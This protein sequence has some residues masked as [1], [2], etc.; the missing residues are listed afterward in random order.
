MDMDN[1]AKLKEAY[2]RINELIA[3]LQRAEADR[4]KWKHAE[5]VAAQKVAELMRRLE[6]AEKRRPIT[7]V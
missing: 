3:K 6:K 1:D 4:D 7:E 5:A 2:R